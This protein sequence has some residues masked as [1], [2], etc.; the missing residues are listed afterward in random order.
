MT[1]AAQTDSFEERWRDLV[2]GQNR[3]WWAS[4]ARGGLT[5]LSWLYGAGVAGYRLCFEW[6]WLRSETLPVPV[7][8]IG[9]L[10]VGG[11]GK[12]TA[13]RWLARLLQGWG[14]HPA[15]ISRGYRAEAGE[16]RD[17]GVVVSEGAGEVAPASVA[18]DEPR[19]LAL[20]LPGV[21]VLAGRRRARVARRACAEFSPDVLL[22]DDAL[23]HW[24]VRRNLDL[25][26]VSALNPFGWEHL[27][28]RG[29]LRESPRALRRAQAV[30]VTHS[31]RIGEAARAAL[32]ARLLEYNPN[33]VLAEA[34]HAPSRIVTLSGPFGE[35]T[36]LAPG[37]WIALSSLG[38]PH[39]F[40][41]TVRDLGATEV[42][43]ARFPDHHPYSEREIRDLAARVESEETRGIVT[44]EKD[45]AKIPPVW[46]G[47]TPC[48]VVVVDLR[49]LSGLDVL[50]ALVRERIAAH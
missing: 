38:D 5:V 1:P 18:G 17:E 32:R 6:G 13:V 15:I 11:T 31:D 8:S 39:S 49:F 40:E 36:Q 35:E 10:T 24:R 37:R 26:L 42:L 4:P 12:T 22:L 21:P 48:R 16:R 44:T 23:Q 41:R 20:S 30:I 43:P 28:P 46:L 34:V 2:S 7:I 45:S 33:L 27:L 14:M 50:E 47:S 25:V 3:A 19:L 29:L 9:N